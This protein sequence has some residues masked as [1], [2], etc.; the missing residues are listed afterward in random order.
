MSL[1]IQNTMCVE[2]TPR[3]YMKLYECDLLYY[4]N[5]KLDTNASVIQSLVNTTRGKWLSY[6]NNGFDYTTTKG[7]TPYH[8][9]N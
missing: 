5:T 1:P 3:Q 8:N 6:A 4:N 2:F 9:C 7:I